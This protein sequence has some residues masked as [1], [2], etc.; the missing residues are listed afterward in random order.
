MKEAT[1][2]TILETA[3]ALIAERGVWGMTLGDVA[4]ELSVSKGT[5]SYYY[6]TKQALIDAVCADCTRSV[7]DRLFSWVD[8]VNAAEPAGD[9]LGRLCE[10][11]LAE[12]GL[13]LFVALYNGAEPE[14]GLEDAVNR[15]MNEWNVMLDVG[16]MRLAPELSAKLRRLLP[17]VLPFLC[18]LAALDADPD[19]AKEAFTAFVLG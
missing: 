1:A 4:K 7:G 18:G 6:P 14:S 5:L 9:A 16:V 19:Y 2:R 10:A 8:S 11:M 13:R 17:A 12:P 15:A 3:S